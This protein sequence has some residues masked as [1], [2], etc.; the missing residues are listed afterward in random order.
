MARVATLVKKKVAAA[1]LLSNEHMVRLLRK[2]LITTE[3]GIRDG[4]AD[5]DVEWE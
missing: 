3:V 5:R 4:E 1:N 2:Y